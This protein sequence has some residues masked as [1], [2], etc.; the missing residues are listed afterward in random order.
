MTPIESVSPLTRWPI[1]ELRFMLVPCVMLALVAC[2]C[3][4]LGPRTIPMDRADYSE[5]ISDSW[6][7]E[8]LLNI[9]KLRYGMPPVFVEVSSIVGGYSVE[10]Q[11]GGGFGISWPDTTRV[12]NVNGSVR[13][14]DRPTITY[15]PLTGN[16]FMHSMIIPI[17]P[18]ELFFCVQAGWDAKVILNA[19]LASINGLRNREF[20]PEGATRAGPEFT[21]VLHLIDSIRDSG[22][23]GVRIRVDEKNR[24]STLLT[25]HDQNITGPVLKEVQELRHLL[26][27]NPE[28]Q[29]FQLVFGAVPSSGLEIAVRTRSLVQI[30]ELIAAEMEVPAEDIQQGRTIPGPRYSDRPL[31][32][33]HCTPD[34]PGDALV[35]VKHRGYWFWVDNCDVPSK[36]GF[37]FLMLLFTLTDTGEQ[38]NLPLITIP[39]Q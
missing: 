2:G 12:G 18:E 32:R 8:T 34:K 1:H 3:R 39:A 29:E 4:S 15:T 38:R 36:R 25:I 14:T 11:L 22:L 17:R 20:T 13:Y 24:Q 30:M 19:G 7:R 9:I 10:T 6:M 28:A 16:K 33:I 35:A 21:R 27:L 5:T 31:I 23:V 37:S 26:R